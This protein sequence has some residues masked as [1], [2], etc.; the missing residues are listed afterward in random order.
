MLKIAPL[1]S[2]CRSE[3]KK[4]FGNGQTLNISWR[5]EYDNLCL[6]KKSRWSGFWG[7]GPMKVESQIHRKYYLAGT[8][9]PVSHIPVFLWPGLYCVSCLLNCLSCT[10]YFFKGGVIQTGHCYGF[11]YLTINIKLLCLLSILWIV[12]LVHHLSFREGL[13][14]QYLVMDFF[15]WP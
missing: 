14:K 6:E 9:S 8:V 13:F 3:R 15:I 11:F 1:K 5:E 2:L 7:E 4:L 12:S 10:S